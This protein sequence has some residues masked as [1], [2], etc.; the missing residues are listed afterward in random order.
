MS[1]YQSLHLPDGFPFGLARDW[2]RPE[3]TEAFPEFER[4]HRGVSV[5]GA[6]KLNR[7][8]GIPYSIQSELR[9]NLLTLALTL[10]LQ[11]ATE[12]RYC[13]CRSR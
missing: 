6:P 9:G 3:R 11:Q 7:F 1:P 12:P 10:T 4:I 5:R 2:H 13:Q 8:R